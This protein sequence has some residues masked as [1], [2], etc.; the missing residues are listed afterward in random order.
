MEPGLV[1]KIVRGIARG[2]EHLTSVNIVHRDLAA[3]N[4]LLDANFEPRISGTVILHFS[5]IVI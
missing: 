5:P 4:V 3:R 2:M 1:F